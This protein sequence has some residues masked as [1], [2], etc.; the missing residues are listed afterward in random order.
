MVAGQTI[1]AWTAD[2][3]QWAYGQSMPNDAFT[4]PTG[5]FAGINQSGP[6]FFVAGTT[7]GSATRSFTIPTDKFLLIPLINSS[8]SEAFLG[9]SP[10]EADLRIDA[11]FI[12][13]H[14]DSLFAVID[15]AVVPEAELFG[16][17]E[18]SPLFN[19]VAATNNP[20][21]H[22]VRP[23]GN[24]VSDGYWLM[25][26]PLGLG[27]HTISFGG[28]VSSFGFT[29]EVTDTINV[30]PEPTTMFLLGTG[31]VGVAGAARRKKKNQA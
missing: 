21:F 28:G 27:T 29:V 9:G 18:L 14:V 24:A 10:S 6:V 13:N 19:F 1:D 22:P 20:F 30:V 5:A 25:L 26:Q 3:W 2:W 15:G 16:H 8:S 11:A 12:I 7:G 23:S 4:D 31:L 17:R